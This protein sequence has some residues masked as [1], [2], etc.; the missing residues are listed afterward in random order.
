M[1]SILENIDKE[2][3]IHPGKKAANQAK[4]IIGIGSYILFRYLSCF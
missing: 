4:A 1:Q 3:L 2:G